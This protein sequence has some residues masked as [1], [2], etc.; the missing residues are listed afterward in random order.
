[1][2]VKLVL[3]SADIKPNEFNLTRLPA[4][5]GR[6]KEATLR[7][8]H[9]Q[10]SR[11]HCELFEEEGELH[12]RDLASLNGTFVDE[13]RVIDFVAMPSGSR[14]MIG[15]VE[16]QVLCGDDQHR[17]PPG[18]A[19]KTAEAT[20]QTVAAGEPIDELE[21]ATDENEAVV[22]PSS[23]WKLSG[24]E[25]SEALAEAAPAEDTGTV[26][27][28]WLLAPDGASQ[29][30]AAPAAAPAAKPVAKLA[31]APAAKPIQPLASAKPAAAGKAPAAAKPAV[32]VKPAATAPASPVAP[33]S[34]DVPT[35]EPAAGEPGSE[36]LDDFFKSIM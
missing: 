4:K 9:P 19:S 25:E 28:D 24:E 35:E 10:V 15:S 14:L 34:F 22:S 8:I 1:M 17:L 31:P 20:E 2:N 5:I 23:V 11:L 13:Q 18:V 26:D 16:F 33:E 6:G 32:P 21:L 3:L 29:A 12:V 7:L 27:L 30:P 36:D